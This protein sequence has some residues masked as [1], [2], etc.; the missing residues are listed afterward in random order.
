MAQNF[1][2]PDEP[3]LKAFLDANDLS[4]QALADLMGFEDS[5]VSL[6]VNDKRNGV[7]APFRLRFQR[8]VGSIDKAD[9]I[10]G[11][12]AWA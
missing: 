5:V 8:L 2:F 1:I 10:L 6:V 7:G 4:Q 11:A 9:H 12:P 3:G